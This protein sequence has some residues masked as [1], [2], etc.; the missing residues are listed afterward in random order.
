MSSIQTHDVIIIGGGPVGLLLAYQLTRFGLTVCVVERSNKNTPEGRYGRA[1]TLFP[2]TLELLDQLDLV[3]PMLQ[4]GF[5]CRSSVTYKDGI[6][7]FPGK[8]WT[9]MENIKGSVFDFALVL[10][11]M[12][13]E[14]I[15][16]EKLDWKNTAYYDSMECVGF[17]VN[18]SEGDGYAVT[19][20]CVAV[21]TQERLI[22]K[23]KYIVGA[24]GGR[25][26][27]RRH[28]DIPFDGDSSEDQWIR[29]DGIVETDMPINRAYGAIETKTHGNVLWAPLDHGATRI[30]YAY[31][32]EIAT[33]YPNGAT[34]EVAVNESIECLR[35]FNLRFKEVHWWTLYKIGQR[36][37][38]NFATRSN[39]I[40]LCGD[41]AHTHSSG[42]AQGLNTGIHDAVNL[43]WKLAL[44][45][46]GVA[47]PAVLDTYT[48]ERQSAVQRLI[49]YDKDISLLMT[50]KWPSWYDGDTSADPNILLGEI[51][52]QAASFNTGLGISYQTN[53]LNQTQETSSEDVS[54]KPGTRAPDLDLTT[55]GT[56]QPVRLHQILHNFCR[57]HILVFTGLDIE[58]IKPTLL[59]LRECLATHPEL[60][61]RTINWLTV[62]GSIGCSPYELLGMQPFGDTYFDPKGEVHR[63]YGI[64]AQKGGVVVIRPDGLVGFVGELEGGCIRGYFSKILKLEV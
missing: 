46:H 19:V 40:F 42:A 4:Q 63:T 22:L 17:E 50:Q 20:D 56:F 3:G 33:K 58:S 1:I 27:V 5:A 59:S 44:Q 53:V 23:S 62:C 55:P 35:P 9:F 12:F 6:Q 38:R 10:R 31:T 21:E 60:G 45:I 15:L 28:A 2:R 48:T 25:S 39:R 26:F 37:A 34:E 49:N 47:H 24:D 41:A 30:G 7:Q 36:M 61:H 29:I 51:F 52:E 32:P 14:D 57:F 64:D 43:A 11:Q 18:E 54:V 13:T 8:V 16:R